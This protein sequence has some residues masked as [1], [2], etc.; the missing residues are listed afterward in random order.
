MANILLAANDKG[1]VLVEFLE[2]GETNIEQYLQ[3]KFPQWVICRD[4]TFVREGKTQL[5]EYFQGLRTEFTCSIDPQGTDFQR[6]VWHQLQQ[7]PFGET[8]S[9]GEISSK[10][11]G[12]SKG[13][14]AVGQ[15]NSKNPIAIIVPCHRVINQGGSLGGFSGGLHI[16]KWLL[17]WE[18][19]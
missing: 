9:Y 5:E 11:L 16:K 13:A 7:I 8:K 4:G 12:N 2:G 17:Q 10:V 1:V 3:V 6:K 18:K 14:R 15:A 19:H